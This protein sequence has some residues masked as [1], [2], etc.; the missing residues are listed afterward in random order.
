[1]ARLL[2]QRQV[3]VLDG[4]HAGSKRGYTHKAHRNRG[5]KGVPHLP[6]VDQEGGDNRECDGG[7]QL[8]TGAE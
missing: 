6:H 2:R 5:N 7:Q 8:I 1:M 4:E 3:D